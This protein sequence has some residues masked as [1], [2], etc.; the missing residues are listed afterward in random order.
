MAFNI[1]KVENQLQPRLA[2]NS[3]KY[4]LPFLGKRKL[5]ITESQFLYL[6]AKIQVV[7][8][9]EMREDG[10]H[11]EFVEKIENLEKGSYCFVYS[12][13]DLQGEFNKEPIMVSLMTNSLVIMVP[14]ED[15][16]GLRLKYLKDYI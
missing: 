14:K 2:Q 12:L 11:K 8:F 4:L 7:Y 10:V 1:H 13:Q 16:E 9:K 6:I 5:D 3:V 15:L